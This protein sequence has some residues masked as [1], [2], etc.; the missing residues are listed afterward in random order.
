[1]AQD[2]CLYALDS[3]TGR[4]IPVISDASGNIQVTVSNVDATLTLGDIEIG[5]VELKDA[6]SGNRASIGSDGSVKVDPSGVTQPIS[7]AQLP[8]PAGA[9]SAAAQAT[10]TT[11][12]NAIAA[13]QDTLVSGQTLTNF[14]LDEIYTRLNGTLTVGTHGVTGTFWQ[15][16]QPV[17]IAAA[18]AVTGTF[19]QGTQPVSV[20]ALP[21]GHNIV[22]SGTI[23]TITNPVSVTGT[24]F[25]ATQPVSAAALP[26]PAGAATDARQDTGNAS[27]ASMLTALA[28]L[29][30][31]GLVSD[32]PNNPLDGSA[33]AL[34][35]TK[36]GR[37]R[38][39]TSPEEIGT[40]TIAESE[41]A[42]WG[43][44]QSDAMRFSGSPWAG[45]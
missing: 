30:A 22:D 18:V 16:T 23:T 21:V 1:M 28:A 17:S 5:A 26:L 41:S 2:V 42:M 8:L 4:F 34:S 29:Q 33:A 31:F 14:Y 43:A 36:Q 3:N 40:P 15:S 27:L 32:N 11:A 13:D 20:A 10:Q 35:L 9:S 38:V 6:S 45:W 19:W 44:M 12:L 39:A 24:F 37:L 25:Q 7:A